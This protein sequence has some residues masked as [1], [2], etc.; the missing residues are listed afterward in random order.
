MDSSFE[1]PISE[2]EETGGR[3]TAT[4][5]ETFL[6][7]WRS[8][9]AEYAP[10]SG[11]GTLVLNNRQLAIIGFIGVLSLALMASLAY[12]AGRVASTSPSRVVMV[13]SA[14][15]IP[16]PE[17][18][19]TA[20]AT[21]PAQAARPASAIPAPDATVPETKPSPMTKALTPEASDVQRASPVPP[22][23]LPGA[24]AAA[25]GAS[26]WQ[27]GALDRGMATV[28]QKYLEDNGLPV[29]LEPVAGSNLV[30]VLVGPAAE[31]EVAALKQKLD[32]L[33]FQAFLKR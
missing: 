6:E 21:P 24:P 27:V 5:Y 14:Q 11:G 12:A 28:S 9:P 26:F 3:A 10:K 2:A 8:A 18:A 23:Q 16:V 15:A 25:Q 13:E 32:G 4:P 7:D 20:L 30:R 29:R 19:K 31:A 33:G 17:Q 22:A 1:E